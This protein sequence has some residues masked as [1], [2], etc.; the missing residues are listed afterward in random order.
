MDKRSK[1]YLLAGIIALSLSVLFP[2]HKKKDLSRNE[3]LKKQVEE[4]ASVD[5]EGGEIENWSYTARFI[6]NSGSGKYTYEGPISQ[7]TVFYK[8]ARK[9]W[10]AQIMIPVLLISGIYVYRS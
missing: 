1:N 10:I 7:H 2:I 5:G 9:L 3:I 4:M 6:G 8:E